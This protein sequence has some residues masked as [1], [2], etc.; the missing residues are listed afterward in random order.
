MI[1][2]TQWFT[3]KIYGYSSFVVIEEHLFTGLRIYCAQIFEADKKRNI[4]IM[5]QKVFLMSIFLTC[6]EFC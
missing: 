4:M 6:V 2:G 3:S 1:R 5:A